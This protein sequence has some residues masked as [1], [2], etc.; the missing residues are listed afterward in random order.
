VFQRVEA[1]AADRQLVAILQPSPLDRLAVEEDAVEAAVVQDS[2]PPARLGDDQGV[3]AGDAGVVQAQVSGD[4]ATDPGPASLDREDDDLAV[5]ALPGQVVALPRE[6]VTRLLQP[7]GRQL[8]AGSGEF[9]FAGRRAVIL[10]RLEDRVAA[11]VGAAATGAIGELLGLDGREL[12][13][14]DQAEEGACARDR[15]GVVAVI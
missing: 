2:Q 3:A 4:A 6:Q 14:A 12:R 13:A 11:E 9:E 8:G 10:A 1:E 7:A 15:A 5:V